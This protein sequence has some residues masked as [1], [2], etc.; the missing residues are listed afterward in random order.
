[1]STGLLTRGTVVHQGTQ[2]L[3]VL[4][5]PVKVGNGQLGHFV[6]DPAEQSLL[7]RLFAGILI[8]FILPHGHRDGVVKDQCP[9][10]AQD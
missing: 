8:V 7:G 10:Q 4:P 2:S 1:M 9:D 3:A 5:V 6:L